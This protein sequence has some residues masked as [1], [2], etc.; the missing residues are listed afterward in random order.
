VTTS[1]F[2]AGYN[3]A[4]CSPILKDLSVEQ[5]IECAVNHIAIGFEHDLGMAQGI[6]DLA[7]G[8]ENGKGN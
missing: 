7:R 1:D 2:Q 5:L 3:A 8:K 4:I 6:F